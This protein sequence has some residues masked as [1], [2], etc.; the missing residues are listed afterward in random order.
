MCV[1]LLLPYVTCE[2]FTTGIATGI[3]AALAGFFAGFKVLKCY[4][5]E[6]CNDKWISTNYTELAASLNNNLYGQ[7]LVNGPLLKH[8]KGHNRGQPSKA[9]VLSFHGGTGTGKNYVSRLVAE[10]MYREGMKSKYVH[11]ISATKEFPH[12]EMLSLYKDKLR[13]MIESAVEECE[14][15]MFIIDEMDKMPA[16]LIDTLKPYLDYYEK[17]GELDFR[18][19]VFFFLSN[20][21]GDDI[22]KRTLQQWEQDMPREKITLKDM[23]EI[24]QLAAY[25]TEKGL[26]HSVLISNNL[27]SAFIPFLPME[28]RHVK[29]CI[30][31]ELVAKGFF[32]VVEGV[33]DLVVQK[34]ADELRY[35]PA[36]HALFSLTGCKR[37]NEKIDY[38]MEEL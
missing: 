34:I 23:E 20:T 30:K 27:I 1:L 13:E 15:S 16:G 17:L 36:S 25:N 4:T 14:H 38:I 3:S 21:A 35:F 33:P 7:H 22:N 11:L 18:K 5:S 31:A 29:Q 9:L 37:I 32:K 12:E 19:S 8:L 10:H 26:W 24:I 28:R 2:L 6:C